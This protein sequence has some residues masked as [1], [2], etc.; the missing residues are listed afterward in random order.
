MGYLGVSSLIRIL[1]LCPDLLSWPSYS[2][3]FYL[4][5]CSLARTG[6]LTQY[7]QDVAFHYFTTLALVSLWSQGR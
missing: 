5:H 1:V 4:P 3:Q 7:H 2:G 6:G